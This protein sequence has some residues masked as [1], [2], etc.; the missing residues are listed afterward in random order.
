MKLLPGCTAE[1][2]AGMDCKTGSTTVIATESNTP[3]VPPALTTTPSNETEYAPAP[4][5]QHMPSPK[6]STI[7]NVSWSPGTKSHTAT[8][9][10][11]CRPSATT[12]RVL[13]NTMCQEVSEENSSGVTA[14]AMLAHSGVYAP[15]IQPGGGPAETAVSNCCGV[16]GPHTALCS[17]STTSVWVKGCEQSLGTGR[18]GGGFVLFGTGSVIA[19]R[20]GAMLQEEVEEGEEVGVGVWDA[21]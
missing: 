18:A 4:C 2:Q 8:S 13:R 5:A 12:A 19:I 3:K 17:T 20:G 9:A 14:T 21:D 16:V 10:P 7:V 15:T 11:V 6:V 1:L